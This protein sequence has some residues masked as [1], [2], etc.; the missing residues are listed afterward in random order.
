MLK[1]VDVMMAGLI[2]RNK[3]T[4]PD[5]NF[6]QSMNAIFACDLCEQSGSILLFHC[7]WN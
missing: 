7:F 6:S 3:S 4:N 2:H 5:E 1:S